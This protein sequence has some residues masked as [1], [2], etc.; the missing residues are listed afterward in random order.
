MGSGKGISAT[1]LATALFVMTGNPAQAAPSAGKGWPAFLY[2]PSAAE[3]SQGC[4]LKSE[5]NILDVQALYIP[6]TKQ[7]YFRYT[8]MSVADELNKGKEKTDEKEKETEEADAAAP[9]EE[10]NGHQD[11]FW[12]VIAPKNEPPKAHDK[13]NAIIYGDVKKKRLV[14]Y[15]YNGDEGESYKTAEYL[16]SV[17]NAMV[18]ET[19]GDTQTVSFLLDVAPI[20][21]AGIGGDKWVGIQFGEEAGLWFHSSYGAPIKY[22]PSDTTP[23]TPA[24]TPP[25][26]PKIEK[27]FSLSSFGFN[28]GKTGPYVDSIEEGGQPVPV[29]VGPQGVA[30]PPD[31][32]AVPPK[33]K[34]DG[35]P[36]ENFVSDDEQ[37]EEGPQDEDEEDSPPPENEDAPPVPSSA[38]SPL[39]KGPAAVDPAAGDKATES[40]VKNALYK[41]GLDL[42]DKTAAKKLFSWCTLHD[43]LASNPEIGPMNVAMTSVKGSPL[44]FIDVDTLEVPCLGSFTLFIDASAEVES[45]TVEVNGGAPVQMKEEVPETPEKRFVKEAAQKRFSV[46]NADGGQLFDY[47][48]NDFVLTFRIGGKEVREEHQLVIPRP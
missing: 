22:S 1:F 25:S 32:T 40:D 10:S 34:G 27:K 13:E 26:P 37:D 44:G 18:V 38:S 3:L 30:V 2:R 20:N 7:F 47:G 21:D 36:E 6:E 31:E 8:T 43:G 33:K 5:D 24:A 14:F 28:E 48:E 12:M 41:D 42:G 45:V 46:S 11:S 35:F 9:A 4:E 19:E 23:A 29:T 15:A 16:G 39:K 17:D